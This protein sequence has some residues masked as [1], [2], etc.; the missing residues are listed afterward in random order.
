MDDHKTTPWHE[1][2]RPKDASAD[3]VTRCKAWVDWLATCRPEQTLRTGYPCAKCQFRFVVRTSYYSFRSSA[4]V[5]NYGTCCNPDCK[6]EFEDY[7]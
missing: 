4:D 2:N 3:W 7:S 6:H 1:A 5:Y